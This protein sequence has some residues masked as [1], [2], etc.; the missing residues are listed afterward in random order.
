[1]SRPGRAGFARSFPVLPYEAR[2]DVCNLHGSEHV[3]KRS[4]TVPHTENLILKASHVTPVLIGVRLV[5][6][7]E[8]TLPLSEHHGDALSQ[9]GKLLTVML[10][11]L[12]RLTFLIRSLGRQALGNGLSL[13]AGLSLSLLALLSRKLSNFLLSLSD[14]SGQLDDRLDA[15]SR[16]VLRAEM[17]RL[18]AL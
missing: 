16:L 15:H 5:G 7:I 12:S 10:T 8:L 6:L 1:L 2:G 3:V 18:T 4:L 14:L 13:L 17:R 11:L 9:L